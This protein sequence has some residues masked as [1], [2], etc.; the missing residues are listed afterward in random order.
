[1]VADYWR[2]ELHGAAPGFVHYLQDQQVTLKTLVKFAGDWATAPNLTVIPDASGA[3]PSARE[4]RS[5]D[6]YRRVQDI[7]RTSG[8]EAGR[9]LVEYEGLNRTRYPSKSIPRWVIE[10]QAFVASDDFLASFARLTKWCGDTV[11]AATKK[12]CDL[13]KHPLFEACQELRD[14]REA[15]GTDHVRQLQAFKQGLLDCVR[16][17]LPRRKAEANQRSFDDLLLDVH[18]ALQ[19][20]GGAALAASLG[21][22][23]RAALIDEFQDT[24]PVQYAIFRAAFAGDQARLFLIGDPK[25]AIYSFRGAD[26]FAYLN[27]AREVDEHFTL[28][29]N[30]RSTQHL[31]DAVNAVFGRGRNP[32][33]FDEIGY[34]DV[35]AGAAEKKD[36]LVLDGMPDPAPF[37]VWFAP[38]S[39]GGKMI[40]KGDA[41]EVVPAAVAGEILRLLRAG[42]QGRATIGGEAVE[43]GHV[44][45]LVRKNFQARLV[46]DALR[47]RRIP[48]VIYSAASLFASHEAEEMLRLLGA[49]AE[50]GSEGRV[51]AALATDLL[52][53]SGDELFAV[54]GD[55]LAWDT[56]LQKF[57]RYHD[58]WLGKGFVVA[59]RAVLADE[60]VRPRL[61][62]FADGERRLTNVLHCVEVLQRAVVEGNL[63][64]EALLHWFG[65]QVEEQSEQEEYQIRLETDAAAVKV[66]TVHKSKGLEYPIVFCPFSWEGLRKTK[67]KDDREAVFHDPGDDRRLV[68]DLGSDDYET[69]QR[70]ARREELAESLRLVYVALTRAKQRTYLVWGRYRDTETSGL[71]YLLHAPEEVTTSAATAVVQASADAFARLTDADLRQA[72]EG[73]VETSGGQVAVAHLP[74]GSSEVFSERETAREALEAEPPPEK[75]PADWGLASFSGFTSGSWE[76][77]AH[78]D[79]D[80]L[81]VEEPVVGLE[82]TQ[83]IFSFPKGA[84][85]GTCLHAIFEDLDFAEDA[86]GAVLALV[87]RQ[88]ARH[89]FEPSWRDPVAGMVDN[90][91]GAR[92]LGAG[93]DFRLR[94]LG[95]E[96]RL[97][98][99]EFHLP[100]GRVTR[101]G[102]R[103]VFAEH[104]GPDLPADIDVHMRALEF[105]PV[106]GLLKGFVDLVFHH[107]GRYY[108]LDWKSNHLGDGVEHY[109][110]EA[111]QQALA[112][113]FYHLQYHLYAVALHRYLRNRLPGYRYEAHFGGAVYVFL[114]GVGP[115]GEGNN[116]VFRAQPPGSV[117][118]AL[119]QYFAGAA[120]DGS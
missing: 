59:A 117:I 71:A 81:S 109:G 67:Q 97:V 91:L 85:A 87:E 110:P 21:G 9:L 103:S 111:L 52:G 14:L 12:D 74:P 41:W 86:P 89:G 23:Y 104:G 76:R 65:R 107:G 47:M 116:G 51:R 33:L 73:L 84:K 108:L 96:D 2:R 40:N 105:R 19:G 24:D 43:P 37:Q 64:P 69:H 10:M 113:H 31:L 57:R 38:R 120:H 83:T 36:P 17:E 32:F 53:V 27:A 94:H 114:R 50:P 8:R 82:P 92:L 98:E 61:L 100:I 42:Q 115:D 34:Q 11:A 78:P 68:L 6:A 58:L 118:D 30:W 18:A 93:N 75:I 28:D 44:A 101:E 106:R 102:L 35:H 26:L 20:S 25:Q 60:G 72:L 77:M 1:V 99:L 39:G 54:A 56:W 46:Q 48:S 112:H 95:C 80:A 15:L 3:E 22:R 13:L 45:V 29:R 55:D 88:L 119:D 66:V 63:G 49:L 16:Q 7:W 70:L 4:E 90:V 62:A 5:R 79:R